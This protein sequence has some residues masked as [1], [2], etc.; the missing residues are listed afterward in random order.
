MKIQCS[1]QD[2][3]SFV[4]D[5]LLI[6]ASCLAVLIPTIPLL[7]MI[8][9]MP[10]SPRYLMKHGKYRKALEA[11]EQ[12]QTTWLLCSRDFMY[13]H[14]QLDFESR[15][16]KGHVYGNL[17]E[18]VDASV[19]GSKEE[20]SGPLQHGPQPSSHNSLSSDSSRSSV[21]SLEIASADS[22][23]NVAPNTQRRDSHELSVSPDDHLQVPSIENENRER[24]MSD[25]SSLDSN[26]ITAA[27]KKIDNPYSYH[28]GVT[29]YFYR[30]W[31]LWDNKR[32]RRALLSACIAMISQQSKSF[33][34][35]HMVITLVRR[36]PQT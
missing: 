20:L 4:F 31:Q 19:Q 16:L 11:F 13:A 36:L 28:I 3:I 6:G 32:C 24:R 23:P 21:D 33:N 14:A 30:L 12:V 35:E 17:A 8:Y 5:I 9:L 2:D 22:T 10:E 26:T 25:N 34:L 15:L 18:R 1:L 7:I 29:G 27:P